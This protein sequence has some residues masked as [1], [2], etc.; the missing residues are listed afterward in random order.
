MHFV[1]LFFK[2]CINIGKTEHF[3]HIWLLMRETRK[4]VSF[5]NIY[6][7]FTKQIHKMHKITS[8]E[9]VQRKNLKPKFWSL[10]TNLGYLGPV[11]QQDIIIGFSQ[12]QFLLILD[13]YDYSVLVAL[14]T[15]AKNPKPAAAWCDIW[16]ILA[17]KVGSHLSQPM[18]NC[19][20]SRQNIA[21][22]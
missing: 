2:N 21:L 11:S 22:K 13:P 20:V 16:H 18:T 5:C 19:H 4:M 12:L 8:L 1:D 17:S 10:G 9:D 3:S 14:Q 15:H 7:F 6:A